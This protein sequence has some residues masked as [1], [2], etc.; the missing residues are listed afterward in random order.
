MNDSGEGPSAP[1]RSEPLLRVENVVKAYGTR[2]ALDHVSLT[3]SAGE[4]VALLGAN[5]AGKST[6]IQLL[7]GLF[8]P[9]EGEIVV[10]GHDLRASAVAALA[11]IGVVFQQQTLDLELSVTANLLFH[12]DLHGI[13]RRAARPLIAAALE[14]YGLS[15]RARERIRALS[16]GNRRRAELA[17]ALLHEPSVL[18]MDEATIGLD[19]GSR[20]AIL[21]EVFRLK[22]AKNIGIL[23]ST[24]LVD[25][26]ELADRII[27][28]RR[29][30]IVF[31]GTHAELM[32]KEAGGD[33]AAIV[34]RLMGT[35]EI[36]ASA[37][38]LPPA[39]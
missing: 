21:D 15:D 20:R 26:I 30:R 4:F 31:N 33:L 8:T 3:V 7:T 28:L 6:L 22:T 11:G 17:R 24:H 14:H 18:L 23:W 19:P 32:A 29:G 9:D 27:V 10:L 38:A 5:G 34:I 37:T 39:A 35:E 36:G 1:N 2:R 12:A 16:G 25:E 13:S